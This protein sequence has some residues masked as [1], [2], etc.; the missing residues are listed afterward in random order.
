MD[1]PF[2]QAYY[3]LEICVK[4]S[5]DLRCRTLSSVL[6]KKNDRLIGLKYFGVVCDVFFALTMK[7]FRDLSHVCLS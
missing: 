4:L 6:G 5:V 7:T 2:L 3:A 1:L